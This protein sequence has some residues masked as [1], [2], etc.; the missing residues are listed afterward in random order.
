MFSNSIFSKVSNVTANT[1][2]RIVGLVLSCV[3]IAVLVAVPPALCVTMR[4]FNKTEGK[5][6][7]FIL[8]FDP[9]D[10]TVTRMPFMAAGFVSIFSGVLIVAPIMLL[11][12]YTNGGPVATWQFALAVFFSSW[13]AYEAYFVYGSAPRLH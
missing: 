1:V 12:P 9:Q 6:G 3:V 7:P 5:K 4:Y 8:P 2:S 10:Y 11:I 13:I